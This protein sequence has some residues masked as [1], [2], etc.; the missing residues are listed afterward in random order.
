MSR[1]S[2]SAFLSVAFAL[3]ACGSTEQPAAPAPA[4]TPEKPI[5]IVVRD[6]SKDVAGFSQWASDVV[7]KSADVAKPPPSKLDARLDEVAA[8]DEAARSK[9]MIAIYHEI[10]ASCADAEGPLEAVA[11]AAGD[12]KALALSENLPIALATCDCEADM[13]ALRAW[14]WAFNQAGE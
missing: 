8:L 11:T 9:E 3:Q 2:S 10:M 14:F 13:G 12:K 1:F 6:C 5:T 7:F 4:P